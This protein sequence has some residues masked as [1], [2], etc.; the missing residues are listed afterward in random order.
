MKRTI[1]ILTALAFTAQADWKQWRGPTG[2][3]HANA[4]LPTTWSES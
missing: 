2:Q 1:L 4:K 3:G